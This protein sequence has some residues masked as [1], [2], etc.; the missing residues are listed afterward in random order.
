MEALVD[1]GL[2]S[3]KKLDYLAPEAN[4]LTWVR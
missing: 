4:K 2:L 3:E 1:L